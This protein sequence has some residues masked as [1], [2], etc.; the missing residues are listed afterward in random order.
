V[1]RI[2]TL[3]PHLAELVY[4]AGAGS[5]LVGVS[6]YSDH[7]AAAAQLPIVGSGGDVNVEAVLALRPDLVLAWQSGNNAAGVAALQRRGI[8]V[9]STEATTLA[10]VA[11]LIRLFG[12]LAGTSS[13]AEVSARAYEQRIAV[14]RDRY[15]RGPSVRVF[16]E[17][18]HEPLMTVNGAHVVSEAL[19]LCGA[20]N[21]FADAGPLTPIVSR[22]QLYARRPDAI[23]STGFFDDASMRAAWQ[24][25]AALEAVRRGRVY[26]VDADLLTRMGPRLA[27]GVAEVCAAVGRAR[28]AK[29]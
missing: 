10:D 13:V 12:T 2:V 22:E 6:T 29:R 8:K 25:F 9:V 4:A 23:L 7:P 28:D 19:A 24:A 3:A 14:L 5:K 16:V 11:R 26:R 27:D 20:T 1:Q 21:L 15:A 17:I 18:W